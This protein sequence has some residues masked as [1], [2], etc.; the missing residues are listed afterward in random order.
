MDHQSQSSSPPQSRALVDT[1]MALADSVLALDHNMQAF[2]VSTGKRFDTIE[3]RLQQIEERDSAEYLKRK[4][5]HSSQQGGVDSG[6]NDTAN[7]HIL[8]DNNKKMSNSNITSPQQVRSHA[9]EVVGDDVSTAINM[10][11]TKLSNLQQ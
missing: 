7:G 4:Q 1:L 3:N 5:Q 2:I 11:E 6:T 9:T 8:S 10:L